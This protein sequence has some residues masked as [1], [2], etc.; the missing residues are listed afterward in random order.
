MDVPIN[1]EEQRRIMR[2]RGRQE[3]LRRVFRDQNA[4]EFGRFLRNFVH[5][6]EVSFDTIVQTIK[7]LIKLIIFLT[8]A[9]YGF[10]YFLLLVI[11]IQDKP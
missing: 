4:N 2:T 6:M 5:N 11:A 7:N 3:S 1:S 9:Y 10:K 8:I